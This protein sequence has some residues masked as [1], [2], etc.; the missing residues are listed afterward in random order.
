M[1]CPGAARSIAGEALEN[2]VTRSDSSVAPTV[3]TCAKLA[4][5]ESALPC[6]RSF[7]AEATIS[8]PA[9]KAFRI[10]CSSIGSRSK[11]PRLRLITPGPRFRAAVR[12]AISSPTVSCPAGLASQSWSLA[13]G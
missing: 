11:P 4:G 8:W 10:A 3:S 13:W 2:E 1:S 7:P 9:P 6:S 5:Y 12:P